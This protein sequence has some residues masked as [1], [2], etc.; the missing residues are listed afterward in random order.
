MSDNRPSL[1]DL[2]MH[3]DFHRRHIG[4]D[5]K[6]TREML[7]VV[8]APSIEQLI[9][10]TIPQNIRLSE[11]IN[12]DPPMSERRTISY[13]RKMKDRNKVFISMIGMGYYGT[14]TPN[15]IKRVVLG[16]PELVHRLYALSG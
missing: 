2:E 7:D 8:G 4:P 12:I 5:D 14:V 9:D 1:F 16:K 11:D 3:Q 10:E 13:V 15:V 6:E